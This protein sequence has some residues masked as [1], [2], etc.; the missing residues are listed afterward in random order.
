MFLNLFK[1][2]VRPHTEYATPI[3]SPLYKKDKIIIENVQRRTTKLVASCKNLSYPERLRKLGLPSL[4]YRRE[5]ADM[6][7]VYKILNDIDIVE[8]DKLFTRAQYTATRGHSFKLHKKRSRLNVR[9]NTFSN[10]V[11][12]TWNNLPDTVVNAPSVNSFK[13][14]LNKHWHGHPSK[15]EPACYQPGH[16]AR[17]YSQ[18]S[19]EAPFIS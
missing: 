17:E 5:R 8:K 1:S 13:S 11:V 7:Q 2:I 15:F 9:A 12:N 14:R 18:N 10:R 6:I 4:E 3:W 19:Q 16:P